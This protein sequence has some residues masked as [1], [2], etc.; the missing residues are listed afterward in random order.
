MITEVYYCVGLKFFEEKNNTY[1]DLSKIR[2]KL[3]VSRNLLYFEPDTDIP[4]QM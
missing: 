2:G 3:T 4:S 1:F